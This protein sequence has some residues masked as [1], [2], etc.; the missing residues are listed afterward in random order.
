MAGCE[1]LPEVDEV[2]AA[3]LTGQGEPGG[4][5]LGLL[6]DARRVLAGAGLERSAEVAESC[7]R[8]AADALLSLPGAPVVVGLK[9]A[10]VGL[11]DAVDACPGPAG[12]AEA[13][14]AP[15]APVPCPLNVEG[16]AAHGTAHASGARADR[17]AAGDLDPDAG[18]RRA[19]WE[20]VQAAAQVLRG[21]LARPGGYHRGRAASIAERLMGVKLGTAQHTAL[22]V[23]GEVYGQTSSTLHGAVAEAGRAA[24]LYAEVLAAARELL[25]PL[26]GRAARVVQLTALKHPGQAEAAELARWADPRATSYFFRSTPAP[27]WLEAL[28]AHAPHLLMPDP[29]AGGLW[30]AGPYLTHLADAAPDAARAWLAQHATAVAA[31]GRPARAAVLRLAGRDTPLVTPAQVRAILAQETVDTTESDAL[32]ETEMLRLAAAWACALPPGEREG[33]WIVVVEQLLAGTVDAEHTLD[34]F[35]RIRPSPA[36]RDYLEADLLDRVDEPGRDTVVRALARQLPHYEVVRLVQELLRTA[37]PAGPAGAPHPRVRMIRAAAAG[38]LRRD[39]QQF[40]LAARHIVFHA[41][42]DRVRIEEP[43]AFD[44]PRL[45]RLVLDLAAADAAA[46]VPLAERTHAWKKFA[47]VEERL[48]DRLLAAHLS[49]RRPAAV[50]VT[51]SRT[52][53]VRKPA[54][55]PSLRESETEQWWKQARQLLPRLLANRPNPEPARLVEQMWRACPA[56]AV[57][58]LTQAART[59]LG[60]A[61]AAPEVERLLPAGTTQV[62]GTAEPLASWLRV[63]DWSPVLPPRV[64]AGWEPLLAKLHHLKG[65]GP[66]NPRIPASPPPAPSAPSMEAQDVRELAAEA[67]LLTAA[68]ALAAA[69]DAGADDYAQV[70]QRLL[71]EDPGPWTEDVPAVLQTLTHPSLR[72]FYLAAAAQSASLPGQSLPQAVTA[73][74]ELRRSAAAEPSEHDR[75]AQQPPPLVLPFADEAVFFLLTYAWQEDRPLGNVLPAALAH[76]HLLAGPLTRPAAAAGER[77]TATAGNA[78]GQRPLLGSE[79]AVQALNCLLEYAAHQ[80]RTAGAIPRETLDLIAGALTASGHHEAVATAIGRHLPL[81]HRHAPDFTADHRAALYALAPDDNRPSP[82]AAWLRWGPPDPSLLAALDRAQ[83]LASVRTGNGG[84][85]EHLADALVADPDFLGDPA[86][87]FAGI[88]AGPGGPRAASWLLE[89]LAARLA[90]ARSALRNEGVNLS[91]ASARRAADRPTLEA[92]TILWR[93]ALAADLPPG[94]LAGAGAFANTALEDAVWAS[95]TLASAEHTPDLVS[96]SAVAERAA[97]HPGSPEA[98]LLTA[99]LVGRSGSAWTGAQIRQHARTLLQA[100]AALPE[101]ERPTETEV[102]RRALVNAGDIDAIEA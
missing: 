42:L 60:P 85:A 26:P 19:S 10:A 98:L 5:A 91:R 61:P 7:L 64:L 32:Q 94:A 67:G 78:N 35:R 16:T 15:S 17:T 28:A 48:H 36:A 33:D 102:L 68:A 72:A 30:P 71:D 49:A 83:L 41:D 58:G 2:L 52:A 44:G 81:L 65:T 93:A 45:A 99:A 25:V 13:D 38:L 69:P 51:R 40:A 18:R 55:P 54:A 92:V 21:Q 46:G 95:L 84:L 3:A 87:V 6:R 90:P 9:S 53:P 29:A 24:S 70:L 1:P 12:P 47:G 34:R 82:A 8:G 97:G 75:P 37:Y 31:A 77:S 80:A 20:R 4:R 76:L 89:M 100:A 14:G 22:E 86:G 74:I 57:V 79:P 59:A 23:W 66:A 27:A 88:A 101:G 63:W 56:D 43:A 39:V 50:G 96:I 11:L 73:A 62:D